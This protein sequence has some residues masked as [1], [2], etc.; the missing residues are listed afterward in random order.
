MTI[1]AEYMTEEELA[2]DLQAR[3]GRGSK[4]TLRRWRA[5]GLGP[6]WGRVGATVIYPIDDARA[7]LRSQI[8]QPSA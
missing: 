1:L 2:S 8:Q 5:L 6:A 3:T 4:R 7:W